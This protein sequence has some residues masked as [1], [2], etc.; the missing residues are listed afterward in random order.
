MD[1]ICVDSEFAQGDLGA[2]CCEG[3]VRVGRVENNIVSE[4]YRFHARD[5]CYRI[6]SLPERDRERESQ[7]AFKSIEIAN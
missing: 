3:E 1:V 2:E 5:I 6:P 4:K 7:R